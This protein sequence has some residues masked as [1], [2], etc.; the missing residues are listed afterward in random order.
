MHIHRYE[1]WWLTFGISALIIFLLIVGFQAFLTGH[2]PPSAKAFVDPEIVDN[3]APFNKP[4]LKKVDGKDDF[5]YELVV[6]ASA[7]FF[8]PGEVEIPKGAKVKI[9]A[10]SKDVVHGF[11]I[12]GTNVNMTLEPGYVSEYITSF[13]KPGEYLLICNEYCGVGH[14][15]MSSIIKVVDK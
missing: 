7:F 8:N 13:N 12:A 6:V 4:G 5:D 11:E 14:H 3:T 1:K 9:M 2:K 10:T 15:T